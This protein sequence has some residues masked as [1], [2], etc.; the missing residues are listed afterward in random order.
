MVSD[1]VT[2]P[3]PLA[4]DCYYLLLG[5]MELFDV[6]RLDPDTYAAARDAME[7]LITAAYGEGGVAVDSE[8]EREAVA[9]WVNALALRVADGLADQIE[10]T[11]S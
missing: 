9:A 5:F 10:S 8:D 2:I 3:V 1:T 6:E 11:E 7:P 4:E